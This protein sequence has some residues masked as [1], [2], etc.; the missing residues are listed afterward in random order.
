MKCSCKHGELDQNLVCPDCGNK[1]MQVIPNVF[2]CKNDN[3]LYKLDTTQYSSGIL[4]GIEAKQPNTE[5]DYSEDYEEEHIPVVEYTHEEMEFLYKIASI[6]EKLEQCNSTE[7]IKVLNELALQ[8]M[9]V[10]SKLKSIEVTQDGEEPSIKCPSCKTIIQNKYF[11]NR[12]YAGK[13]YYNDCEIEY[14]SGECPVCGCLVAELPHDTDYYNQC[15]DDPF[16][17]PFNDPFGIGDDPFEI[18]DDPFNIESKSFGTP[19]G[20]DMKPFGSDMKPFGSDMK[21]FGSEYKPFS[22]CCPKCGNFLCTCDTKGKHKKK[23]KK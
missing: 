2:L 8:H 22:P 16:K 23:K 20:S 11:K 3:K 17:D 7:E 1:F 10:C 9:E 12:R 18:G 14:D 21:P 19:F 6:K 5:D 4:L 13:T 15:N